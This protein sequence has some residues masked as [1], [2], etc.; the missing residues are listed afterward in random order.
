MSKTCQ[1]YEFKSA[2]PKVSKSNRS[3]LDKA[4]SCMRCRI[5]DLARC[6]KYLLR[7]FVNTGTRFEVVDFD[8]IR[9]GFNESFRNFNSSDHE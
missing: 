5:S 6:K 1:P 8:F 9:R 7:L 2:Q 3:T 4:C